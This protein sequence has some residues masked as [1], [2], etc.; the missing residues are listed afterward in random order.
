MSGIY[1]YLIDT[2][3]AEKYERN[4]SEAELET[5]LREADPDFISLEDDERKRQKPIRL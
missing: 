3:L 1:P 5:N 2:D 4:K